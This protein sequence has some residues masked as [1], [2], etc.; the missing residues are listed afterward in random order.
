L[1]I[2]SIN[3]DGL[4]NQATR[5]VIVDA[6][7]LNEDFSQSNND[8]QETTEEEANEEETEDN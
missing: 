1:K 6:D 5:T 3:Q 8:N 7:F 4:L 2:Y